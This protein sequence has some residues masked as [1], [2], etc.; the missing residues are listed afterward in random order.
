MDTTIGTARQMN[1]D[2][3][4]SGDFKNTALNDLS[5]SLNGTV[6][7]SYDRGGIIQFAHFPARRGTSEYKNRRQWQ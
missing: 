7:E 5:F 2:F 3:V 6:K 4:F 1:H